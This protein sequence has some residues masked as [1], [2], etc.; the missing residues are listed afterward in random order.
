MRKKDVKGYECLYYVTDNGEVWSY[1]REYTIP[2]H[3]IKKIR[4]GRKIKTSKGT[5]GYLSISLCKNGII[6]RFSHHRLV[7]LHFVK[8]PLKKPQVNHINGIKTDNRAENLEWM[9][10]KENSIHAYKIGLT[11]VP[12]LKG[13]Q[14]KNSK[15]KKKDILKIRELLNKGIFQKDIAK[16]FKIDQTTVSDIKLRKRWNHVS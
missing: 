4:K 14:V 1:D 8:N 16:L 13:E 15:L 6:E 10:A 5:N 3:N 9:T 2:I 12:M 7:A 11:K